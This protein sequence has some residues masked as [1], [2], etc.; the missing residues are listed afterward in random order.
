MSKVR[1][2]LGE[3]KYGNPQ[4]YREVIYMLENNSNVVLCKWDRELSQSAN[5]Q[6]ISECN[7]VIVLVDDQMSTK[8]DLVIGKGLHGI[9]DYA[10]DYDIPIFGYDH[11]NTPACY[12]EIKNYELLDTDSWR[13]YAVLYKED[14]TVSP[15]KFNADF[16]LAKSS[17]KTVSNV[18]KKT[19]MNYVDFFKR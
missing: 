18:S 13:T 9:I 10:F 1:V 3:S 16:L 8:N 11:L 2:W 14:H 5:Y 12:H 17:K 19:K 6:K 4:A 15:D 7:Y